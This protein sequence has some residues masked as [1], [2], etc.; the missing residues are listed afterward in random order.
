MIGPLCISFLNIVPLMVWTYNL[1]V[2]FSNGIAYNWHANFGFKNLN[3]RIESFFKQR[4]HPRV[5]SFNLWLLTALWSVV[6]DW[7]DKVA[8]SCVRLSAL[9]A[10]RSAYRRRCLRMRKMKKSACMFC[11]CHSVA[12]A[13]C[14]NCRAGLMLLVEGLNTMCFVFLALLLETRLVMN[15][16]G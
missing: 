1:S 12:M 4:L 11:L 13:C 16:Y 7:D 10:Y 2:I 6:V 15:F 3:S 8:G 5:G 9:L 14:H